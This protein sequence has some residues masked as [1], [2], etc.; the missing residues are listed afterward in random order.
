MIHSAPSE[1]PVSS[2]TTATISSSPRAGRQ[3][4][5]A[6]D[7][8][9]AISAATCDFMS[10]APRPHRKPSAISPD[11]GSC[12]HS[13]AFGEHRVDVA[14]VAQRRTRRGVGRWRRAAR[15]HEVWA[16]GLGA[17]QLALEARLREVVGQ[18]FLR[19]ALVAGRVD[20]VEADQA[21]QQLLRLSARRP[22]STA[23]ALI[24]QIVRPSAH[25]LAR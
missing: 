19:R 24:A 18:V 6:S 13:A 16:A 23:F 2:S 12:V 17:E 10:S 22:I 9:A 21:R 11:H 5:R 7:A 1:P 3:P 4:E 20:G 25:L 8:A 15:A 14:E